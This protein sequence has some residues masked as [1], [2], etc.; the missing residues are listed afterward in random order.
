M[1]STAPSS[2]SI[3]S[4]SCIPDQGISLSLAMEQQTQET[5]SSKGSATEPV[6]TRWSPKPEQIL[7]LESIFNSGMVNPPKEE[8]VKIRKLLENFGPVGDANVFYWFQNRRS[9]SRRRQR[10]I[11]AAMAGT[12]RPGGSG[13]SHNALSSTASFPIPST[14]F[15]SSGI[16]SPSETVAS[17][18]ATS[19]SSVLHPVVGEGVFFP[20]SRFMDA[21]ESVDECPIYSPPC[22][23]TSH[24]QSCKL[25]N[26]LF[27]FLS[28]F[29]IQIG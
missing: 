24:C 8:T 2:P 20:V 28:N 7:I 25:M 10:Q 16:V 12:T 23:S 5:M 14:S 19:R 9:R 27:N 17:V 3:S 1:H 15:F 29:F 11:Q 4:S 26:S 18:E 6:R 13:I 21:P 22:A